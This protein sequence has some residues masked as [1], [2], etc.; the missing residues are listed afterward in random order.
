MKP[1]LV[2]QSWCL[3]QAGGG[4]SSSGV[5]VLQEAEQHAL[6]RAGFQGG[7]ALL[8]VPPSEISMYV[9]EE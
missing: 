3:L 9:G 2:A 1:S 8:S 4:H 5:G 6:G 7:W